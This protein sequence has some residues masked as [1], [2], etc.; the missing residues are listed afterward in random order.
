MTLHINLT[1]YPERVIK[2]SIF[3]KDNKYKS[4]LVWDSRT[5][6]PELFGKILKYK[7][8]NLAEEKGNIESKELVFYEQ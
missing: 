8:H 3:K 5:I 4:V 7:V 2:F 1:A 6:K